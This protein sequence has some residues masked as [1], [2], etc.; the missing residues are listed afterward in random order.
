MRKL[1]ITAAALLAVGC[2]TVPARLEEPEP[3]ISP[4]EHIT[5]ETTPEGRVTGGYLRDG[6]PVPLR[7]LE[8]MILAGQ[9]SNIDN[10]VRWMKGGFWALPQTLAA[11][12]TSAMKVTRMLGASATVDFASTAI[13]KIESTG[14]TVTGALVGDPC[15]VGVPA[16]AGALKAQYSCYVSAADTV[17]VVF[18]SIDTTVTTCTLNAASPSTCTATVSASS[19]CTC[20]PVGATAAIAAAGCAVGLVST[21]LTA[22]S[23]NGLGNVVN[24]ICNAPVDPASGTFYVRTVSSQ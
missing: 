5:V 24:L 9:V 15:A 8:R 13:G 16:A 20:T 18:E 10:T 7:M 6:T 17:K 14:I 1:I 4:D 19:T 12:A 11:Q 2:A 21:T 3:V 22:T 23:A